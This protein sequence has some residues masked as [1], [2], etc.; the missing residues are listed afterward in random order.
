MHKK[1][2]VCDCVSQKRCIFASKTQKQFIPMKKQ[3][4]LMIALLCTVV[5]TA[6]AQWTGSGTEADPYLITS[7]A[8]WSTL[9]KN[10]NKS[11]QCQ[12]LSES[13]EALENNSGLI[14]G[15]SDEGSGDIVRG[16]D[17]DFDWE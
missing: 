7:K 12:L 5:L 13:V 8:D 9:C 6:R 3:L 1:M 15:G 17:Y 16:R 10:V 14:I 2:I 4:F 11:G